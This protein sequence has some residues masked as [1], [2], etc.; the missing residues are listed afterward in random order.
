MANTNTGF[1]GHPIKLI[2]NGDGTFSISVTSDVIDGVQ[3]GADQNIAFAN[4]AL[5][6]T[7][8]NLDIV[9]PVNVKDR[10]VITIK[11]P[12]TVSD[13]T[14]KIMA[15]CLALGGATTYSLLDSVIIPKSQSITGTTISAKSYIVEG[16]FIGTDLRFVI[17]N[18]TALGVAE[19]FT[20][21]IRVWGV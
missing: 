6:N 2:D 21:V 5:V 18:D 17:S 8:I 14:V 11:N 19:G 3:L 1:N 16:L 7:Q 9:K 13:I 4:S 15:K 20:A 12:S 10:Y